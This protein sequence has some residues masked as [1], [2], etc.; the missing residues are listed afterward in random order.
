MDELNRD[1]QQS[2]E[3]LSSGLDSLRSASQT[4]ETE[5]P[6][7]RRGLR[8]AKQIRLSTMLWVTRGL[9]VLLGVILAAELVIV[10]VIQDRPSFLEQP[11]VEFPSE[12]VDLWPSEA[13]LPTPAVPVEE[14]QIF[15]E[16]TPE[17]LS[18]PA[19]FEPMEIES[20]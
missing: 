12:P 7:L 2:T 19:L 16:P 10:K 11:M 20:S 8:G 17:P 5:A 3:G 18:E 13:P 4:A 6:V 15:I 1:G 9:I 14:E